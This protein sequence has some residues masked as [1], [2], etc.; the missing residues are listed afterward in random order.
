MSCLQVQ[1]PVRVPWAEVA[2]L[3]MCRVYV[4]QVRCM[5]TNGTGYWSE[6]SESVYSTPQNSR[7]MVEHHSFHSWL[8]TTTLSDA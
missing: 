1:S 6:W 3:D 2:V 7:G 8:M 4:V 5:H